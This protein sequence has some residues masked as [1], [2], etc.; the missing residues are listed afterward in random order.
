MFDSAIHG[1]DT[2]GPSAIIASVDDGCGQTT[3]TGPAWKC[4]SDDPGDG[5][6]D[7][8]FD[9][10]A[11]VVAISGG[12]NGASPWGVRPG[13]SMASHWIWAHDLL[14]TD[15]AWC[16]ITSGSHD[17]DDGMYANVEGHDSGQIHVGAD[18]SAILYV[19]GDRVDETSAGQ[20]DQTERFAFTAPC[21]SPTTY[22]FKVNDQAGGAMLISTIN[23]CGE[24]INTGPAR[25]KCSSSCDSGWEASGFDDSSWPYALSM[26]IN[27]NPP[28]GKYEVD[29]NADFI[30]HGET[31]QNGVLGND[32]AFDHDERLACCRYVS[33]HQPIN[34]N[35]ARSKFTSNLLLLVIH[36][37]FLRGWL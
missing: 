16:R 4:T 13:I 37:A 28:Y 33:D 18:D 14:G 2:G 22:A 21:A 1:V 31:G 12:I 35:A 27:G 25:W 5:W 9:D 11:W 36:R 32:D 8:G 26:G 34:C 24:V 19:N 6:T 10:S 3:E 15:E 30:W 29:D 20:W 7:Q 17:Y 23:H